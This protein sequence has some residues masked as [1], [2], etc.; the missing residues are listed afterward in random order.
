MNDHS[1]WLERYAGDARRHPEHGDETCDHRYFVSE[2]N[3]GW[4][5]MTPAGRVER[6]TRMEP[7][8]NTE[9]WWRI[10]TAHTGPNYS[11]RR[12]RD[13]R[14]DAIPRHWKA[15]PHLLF[16]DL[17]S[18]RSAGGSYASMH[19]VPHSPTDLIPDFHLT[20]CE[21]RHLGPG[22]GW[23]VIDRPDGGDATITNQPNKAKARRA[24][25]AAGQHHAKAL[26]MTLF[27]EDTDA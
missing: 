3:I 14:I 24:L 7:V 18:G 19:I 15:A 6:V 11:W 13:E 17:R 20:L 9:Y 22:A 1:W 16:V 12:R 27:K 5:F 10:W 4:L 8:D 23:T 2:L 26:G 25:L 21:A